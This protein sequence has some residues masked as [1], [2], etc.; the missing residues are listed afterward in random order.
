[1]Y[2]VRKL[3]IEIAD[4]SKPPNFSQLVAGRK[5]KSPEYELAAYHMQMLVEEA[6]FVRG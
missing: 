3:L 2:L 1:M 5:E 4:A 6:G